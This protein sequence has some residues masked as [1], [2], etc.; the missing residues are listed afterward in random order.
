[1]VT[2]GCND[3]VGRKDSDIKRI[4]TRLLLSRYKYNIIF[5]ARSIFRSSFTTPCESQLYYGVC[6]FLVI[7]NRK[8]GKIPIGEKLK[9]KKLFVTRWYIILETQILLGRSFSY[10]SMTFRIDWYINQIYQIYRIPEVSSES[11]CLG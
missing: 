3:P 5:L 11:R 2:T 9:M 8:G 10:V 7:A 4:T 6:T 1:M